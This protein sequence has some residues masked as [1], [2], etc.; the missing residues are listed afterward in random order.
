MSNKDTDEA[1]P[2]KEEAVE[3]SPTVEQDTAKDTKSAER[4]TPDESRPAGQEAARE[5]PTQPR[6]SAAS[7]A[8]LS[9]VVAILALALASYVA[10]Q[11]RLATQDTAM[12]D[13]LARLESRVTG[14]ADSLGDVES[15]IEA[16]PGRRRRGTG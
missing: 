5:A 9:F 14:S 12:Q 13:R 16:R 4:E 8:W 15:R 7:I 2:A 11:S 6:R 1:P 10:W 3:A